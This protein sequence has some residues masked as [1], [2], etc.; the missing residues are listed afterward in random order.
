MIGNVVD[1][2]ELEGFPGGFFH[3]SGTGFPIG[4]NAVVVADNNDGSVAA[5]AG[6]EVDSDAFIAAGLMLGG[7]AGEKPVERDKGLGIGLGKFG[8]DMRFPPEG[9]FAPFASHF[10]EPAFGGHTPCGVFD[11]NVGRIG[12]RD[13]DEV[14]FLIG[15][16]LLPHTA[17][18]ENAFGAER[19]ADKQG[20]MR[21]EGV[22]GLEDFPIDAG[23][24]V[25]NESEVAGMV[26]GES[27]F[28]F[29]RVGENPPVFGDLDLHRLLVNSCLGKEFV[30]AFV[31][32]LE[33]VC[34]AD[35]FKLRF[36]RSG[37]D[38]FGVFVI[39]KIPQHESG[40]RERLADRVSGFAESCFVGA[41]T[42]REFG[43]FTPERGPVKY[44][45]V[46]ACDRVSTGPVFVE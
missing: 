11:M 38:N 39:H 28:L 17:F 8:K 43:L 21:C 22:E 23:C 9:A 4:D 3:S 25:N 42:F 19:V 46:V 2:F 30:R 6:P 29:G 5:A 20:A 45:F 31:E 13:G 10:L 34:P 16:G 37:N 40:N 1:S 32:R 7:F 14:D 41:K 35:F 15:Q 24:F 26:A 33:D 44:D 27:F 18:V 36:G 12:G